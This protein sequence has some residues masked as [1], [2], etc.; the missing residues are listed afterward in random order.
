MRIISFVFALSALL[1]FAGEYEINVHG[2]GKAQKVL[3][4][5]LTGKDLANLGGHTDWIRLYDRDGNV[6]PWALQRHY[7]TDYAKSR[8]KY[9][10]KLTLVKHDEND[11]SLMAAQRFSS[12]AASDTAGEPPTG[13]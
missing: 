9:P 1:L 13:C 4:I 7:T 11:G 2:I 12:T 6:V 10:F 5:E 8:V 3:A